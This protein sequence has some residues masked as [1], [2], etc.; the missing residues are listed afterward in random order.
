M[1]QGSAQVLPGEA[2]APPLDPTAPTLINGQQPWRL[3]ALRQF[4]ASASY[5]S[6]LADVERGYRTSA[7]LS[8]SYSA[9]VYWSE[10]CR[11]DG[12]CQ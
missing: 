6:Y 4:Q 8:G 9:L 12:L 2:Y 3:K 5:E 1:P 10:K 11:K 7:D